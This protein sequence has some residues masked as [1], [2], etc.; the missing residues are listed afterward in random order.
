M[1][2]ESLLVQKLLEELSQTQ[3][4]C[5]ELKKLSGGTAN[6]LYRGTLIEH[7][8]S[9]V[10]A[11]EA[12]T[13]TVVIKH[14]EDHVPGLWL[15][16]F[17]QW[18]SEPGQAS[19][20]ATISQNEEAR[21]L[22][23]KIT[24]DSF[25]KVLEIYPDL[26]EGHMETLKAVKDA[27]TAEFSLNERPLGEDGSWGLIHGDFWTGNVLL[28][29][30][31]W[32]EIRNPDQAPN[33]LFIIDWELAQFGHRAIDVGAMMADLYE[34]KHFKDVDT[35]IP[36]MK[37]FADGYG[38]ISDEMAFRTAIHAGVHLICWHIRGNPNLPLS[39]PMD[40]VLS[41]LALG[42][43]FVLKGWEKDRQWF[44]SSVLAP[45]FTTL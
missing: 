21:K 5:S 33:R 45:L 16:S 1:A 39:V 27:M 23:C 29:D 11:P 40:K 8:D 41:A 26:V 30:A 2:D 25:L 44:E 28:P 17:H 31:P 6:Y 22:K 18:M 13:K 15:R 34:R 12:V 43:D 24:Y 3:Y 9:Q 19:L 37:G 42:R 35:V 14:S 38:R 10:D 20:R 36:A 32:Q 4:A 7:L